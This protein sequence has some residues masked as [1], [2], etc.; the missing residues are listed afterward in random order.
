MT[1][2]DRILFGLYEKD[3]FT[4]EY[5]DI[6]IITPYFV[7]GGG[8]R[9]VDHITMKNKMASDRKQK[10]WLVFARFKKNNCIIK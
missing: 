9:A 3:N 1:P 8:V 2:T 5:T 6:A 7:C 10:S 4:L